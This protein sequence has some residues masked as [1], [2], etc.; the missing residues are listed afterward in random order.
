MK[1]LKRLRNFANFSQFV[2][3]ES[4]FLVANPV[5][6]SLTAYYDIILLSLQHTVSIKL[7]INVSL[8]VNQKMQLPPINRHLILLGE[9]VTM[10]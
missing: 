9:V 4:V 8:L 6:L 5:L 10:D 1:V 7:L 3:L 2:Q